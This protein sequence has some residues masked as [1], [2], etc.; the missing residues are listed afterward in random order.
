MENDM[1]AKLMTG[2]AALAL[3]A[4]T[5]LASAAPASAQ[6]RGWHGG[7]WHGGFGWGGALAAGVVGGAV[8]AATSPLW[9]PGYYDYYGG[10]YPYGPYGYDTY[11]YV[12][13]PAV[14]VA[15]GPMVAQG[16]DVAWCEARYRSYDP[17]SGTYLGFDGIRH[18]CP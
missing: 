12:P 16:G 3:T 8:V 6:W 4:C 2:A 10:G 13:G 7:G 15:P 5:I 17:A 18:P 14:A 11:D 9:A 1:R